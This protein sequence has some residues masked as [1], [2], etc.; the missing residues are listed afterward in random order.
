LSWK[1]V[2]SKSFITLISEVRLSPQVYNA[3]ALS[4]TPCNASI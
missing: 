3:Y 1:E 4:K 2:F